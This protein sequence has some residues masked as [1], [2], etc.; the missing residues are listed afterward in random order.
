MSEKEYLIETMTTALA[1][2]VLKQGL[3]CDVQSA[4]DAVF[5]SETYEK[6]CQEETKLMYQHP[7]YVFGYL[8]TELVTGKLC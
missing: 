6:L 7:G 1:D 3:A 2:A 4:L 8:K 5:N